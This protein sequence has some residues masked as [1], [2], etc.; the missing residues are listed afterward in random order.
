MMSTAHSPVPSARGKAQPVSIRYNEPSG[1]LWIE[2]DA[3]GAVFR[4]MA[5]GRGRDGIPAAHVAA[6]RPRKG[7]EERGHG[8]G[9]FLTLI[10]N[11]PGLGHALR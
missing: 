8:L 5:R 9:A 4:G 3:K 6:K 11:T 1:R 10:K 7:S 2:D